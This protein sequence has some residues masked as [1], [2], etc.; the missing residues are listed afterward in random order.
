MSLLFTNFHQILKSYLKKIIKKC[1]QGQRVSFKDQLP[2]SY[3]FN[4]DQAPQLQ[5]E[6]FQQMKKKQDN[7][8]GDNDVEE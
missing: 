2:V 1:L 5:P 3:C 6:Q 4:W 7:D 8:D